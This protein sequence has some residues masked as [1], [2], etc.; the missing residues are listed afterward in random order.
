MMSYRLACEASDLFA[1]IGVVSG[2]LEISP[3]QPAHPVAVVHIHGA[4]DENVPLN[5][6]VGAKQLGTNEVRKPVQNTIDFWVKEDGC[7]ATAKSQLPDVDRVD[8]SGCTAGTEVDY[9]VIRD[10]GHAWPGGRQMAG[11]LD[12]PSDALDATDVIWDFFSKHKKP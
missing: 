3:C 10:G 8:Y 11:F 6:G 2:I 1:A 7:S 12:K 5:G 4:K 9:Y